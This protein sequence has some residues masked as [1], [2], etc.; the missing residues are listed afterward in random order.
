MPVS[1][2]WRRHQ[3][4]RRT[5]RS[6]TSACDLVATAV[7]LYGHEIVTEH[8]G[9]TE[10]GAR[11]F[12][13]LSLKSPYTGYEDMVALRN[14][15]DKS[16]PAM[17]GVGHR[18]FCCDNM[19]LIADQSIRRKHTA[20]LKRDLPG[21]IGEMIEPLALHR[22]AQHRKIL[23][24]QRTELIPQ[25]ADHALM[26]MYRKGII[27]VQRIPEVLKQWQEPEHDRGGETAWRMFNAATFA[28]A[29]R[30]VE[31]ADVTP[32]LFKVIDGV[33]EHVA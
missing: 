30:V 26:E 17:V 9:V 1:A 14:S 15:H 33:C 22:E 13:V 25:L 27:S 32:R 16:F 10:D 31:S 18:V 2:N 28:L 19:A 20:N 6:L 21:V 23:T 4:R 5:C 29:G 7:G 11:F 24:Y 12:G 3:R 8:F